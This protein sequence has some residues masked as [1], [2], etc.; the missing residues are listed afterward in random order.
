MKCV[1]L[2][3]LKTNKPDEF[4]TENECATG[5]KEGENNCNKCELGLSP[6]ACQYFDTN[7]ELINQE[8]CECSLMA[9]KSPDRLEV[10]DDPLPKK[11][12]LNDDGTFTLIDHTRPEK[13]EVDTGMC[14]FPDQ[15]VLNNY[16]S[17]YQEI[18]TEAEKESAL[19]TDDRY[20][21][22]AIFTQLV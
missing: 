12:K 16:I 14:P 9:F 10:I 20:D 17:N 8:M 19:H 1:T 5:G 13:I 21:L 18:I 6:D 15:A 2:K 22:R 7:D 3:K 11:K 4:Q